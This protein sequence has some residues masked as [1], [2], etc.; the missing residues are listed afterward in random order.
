MT[1]GSHLNVESALQVYQ[2]VFCIH[3]NHSKDGPVVAVKQNDVFI[4]TFI[5]NSMT[6]ECLER[7]LHIIKVQSIN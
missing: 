7:S 5:D 4:Y 3:V 1:P 2:N 6:L